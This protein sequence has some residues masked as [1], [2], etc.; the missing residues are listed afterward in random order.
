[1]IWYINHNTQTGY[2]RRSRSLCALVREN[3]RTIPLEEGKTIQVHPY[4]LEGK[5][6]WQIE[7]EIMIK[8]VHTWYF[9]SSKLY[10][11]FFFDRTNGK[12][13]VDQNICCDLLPLFVSLYFLVHDLLLKVA[14]MWIIGAMGGSL[15]IVVPIP[16]ADNWMVCNWPSVTEIFNLSWNLKNMIY[17]NND[18]NYGLN[19]NKTSTPC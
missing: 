8:E 16:C 17:E 4:F 2:A 9:T 15:T 18:Q 14:P 12:P 6:E 19:Q 1:M 13:S 10:S 11:C 3:T 5:G 7:S